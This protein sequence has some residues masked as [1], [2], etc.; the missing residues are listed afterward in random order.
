V[1]DERPLRILQ[2]A[3]GYPPGAMGGVETYTQTLCRSLAA[4]GHAVAVFCREAAPSRAEFSWRDDLVDGIPVRRVTNNFVR[5][6]GLADYYVSAEAEAIFASTLAEWRPDVIH[7]QHAIGLSASLPEQSASAGVPTAWTLWDYWPICPVNTLLLKDGTLCPG[8]HRAV[9]CF[10]CIYG[11]P[12]PF[13]G[14]HIPARPTDGGAPAADAVRHPFGL[15]EGTVHTLRRLLPRTVRLR[16]L[17]GYNLLTAV[18]RHLPRRGAAGRQSADTETETLPPAAVAFRADFMRRALSACSVLVAPLPFVADTYV[19]FGLDRA[20]IRCLEPGMDVSGWSRTPRSA[21]PPDRPLRLGYIGSLMRH[22]GVDVLVRA[23][24]RLDRR[25]V[26]LRLHGFFVPGDPYG[27]DLRRLAQGDRRVRLLGP[28]EQHDLPRVL[29]EID[30]LLMPA[31]WHET[32][33]FVTRE[34]V[35]AGVPVVAARMGGMRAAVA[36]GLNGFLLPPGDADAW[37]GAIDRLAGD[38]ELVGRMSEAQATWPVRSIEDD[39]AALEQLY[40]EIV[41]V[42]GS[43]VAL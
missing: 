21:P 37:A 20:H 34:A 33:S 27:S 25:D 30:V 41:T 32:F 14:R 29:A 39:A 12:R 18:A 2:V 35:L 24:A 10:T 19:D 38:R 40:R 3:N 26:E 11:S 7:F 8:S 22:K 1:T 36:D 15:D 28:Y 17:D 13:P 42:P 6:S 16:L 43:E 23:L 4:R 31:V 5:V 9:N